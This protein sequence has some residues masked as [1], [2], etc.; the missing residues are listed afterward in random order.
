MLIRSAVNYLP[1]HLEQDAYQFWR[2]G[3]DTMRITH[4]LNRF[5]R[6]AAGRSAPALTVTEAQVYNSLHACRERQR[7]A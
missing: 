1:L 5:L 2:W 4:H 7:A 3:W 6:I